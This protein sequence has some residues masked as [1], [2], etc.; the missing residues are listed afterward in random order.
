MIAWAS[1]VKL[2][3]DSVVMLVFNERLKPVGS[4]IEQG[5]DWL[6]QNGDL[7]PFQIKADGCPDPMDFMFKLTSPRNEDIE[8]DKP[9]ME[10]T[11]HDGGER[12]EVWEVK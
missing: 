4:M 8:A 3:N 7:L 1:K 2:L 12:W 6:V 9:F 10:F 11:M 5:N